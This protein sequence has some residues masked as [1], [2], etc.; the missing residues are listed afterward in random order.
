MPW[1]SIQSFFLRRC[2]SASSYG[3]PGDLGLK[4]DQFNCHIGPGWTGGTTGCAGETT[5]CM[6]G[7]GG[8]M[9]GTWGT[10]GD[11][12]GGGWG[13]GGPLSAIF[14]CVADKIDCLTRKLT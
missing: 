4:W 14:I 11:T 3:L 5:G 9:G 7:A 10:A 13:I 1:V 12:N 8:C 6:G 2:A